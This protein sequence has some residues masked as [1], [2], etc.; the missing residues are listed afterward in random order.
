MYYK[1]KLESL[2]D[3]FGTENILLKPDSLMVGD[4]KYP[5]VDD[6]ILLSKPN[7]YTGF[8]K[9]RLQIK[10]NTTNIN[11]K[12]FSEEIQYT[13]GEEWKEYDE[14]LSEHKEEFLHYFDLVKTADLKDLRVCDLGCG[15]GRW[16]FHLKDS[17]RELIL[18][19]FSD[20]IFA[21]RK[22]LA[23]AN[24]TLF[25]MCDLKKL[26]FKDD[27]VDFLFCLGV[28][29]H[30]PT[31]CLDEVRGL[32]RFAPS[33]LIYLYYALDNRPIH[34]RLLLKIV[35]AFRLFISKIRNPSSRKILTWLI[36]FLIYLPLVFLGRLLEPLK[37]SR[38][39]P[40]YEAYQGKSIKR[41]KQDAYDRFFTSIEQRVS[42][43]EILE[44]KD[45]FSSITISD[46]IPYW[47]FL[48]QR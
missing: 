47:H 12:D 14:V 20:A 32:R 3:I 45:T 4:T 23:D 25:F 6:V 22:N 24:N 34:F 33:L 21:A 9:G 15:N 26:P 38:Y 37:L 35:T 19:D 16:S 36:T 17:C 8:V 27:F 5:I 48:C 44:L 42:H 13:F 7:Q 39:I 41:I 28:L 2:K 31:S 30:L 43:R 40:L 29:H 10:S 1:D 46:K 11:D 18:V